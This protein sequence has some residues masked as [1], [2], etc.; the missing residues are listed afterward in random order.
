MKKYI[1]AILLLVA[2]NVN[3][4]AQL[5]GLLKKA[6]DKITEKKAEV[7]KPET[8]VENRSENTS[9]A[10]PK[11]TEIN[12]DVKF[13]FVAGFYGP[14]DGY[15]D[16]KKSMQ[17][18][19]D[20][21]KKYHVLDLVRKVGEKGIFHFV[22][23]YPE[24]APFTKPFNNDIKI[25][26]SSE[27]FKEGKG[28]VNNFTS[29]SHIYARVENTKGT[30]KDAFKFTGK[31]DIL[32]ISFVAFNDETEKVDFAN[33][34]A[35]IYLT[36]K[37]INEKYIDFDILPEASKATFH[38]IDEEKYYSSTIYNLFTQ[39]NFPKSGNYKMGVEVESEVK[40][41]WGN[42]SKDKIQYGGYFDIIFSPSD[43]ATINIERQTIWDNRKIGIANAPRP[44]PSEWATKTSPLTMGVTQDKLTQM[45][46]GAD[47]KSLKLIKFFASSSSGGWT[48][49][50][51]QDAV[52]PRYRHSNQYYTVFY[53]VVDATNRN[54]GKCWFQT[55]G[56]R[57]QYMGGG[58]Y[59]VSTMDANNWYYTE[60][61]KMK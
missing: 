56:L 30:I 6:K 2:V 52:V 44:L 38:A 25:S 54:N 8:V 49:V 15:N 32:T 51:D 48:A 9:T 20:E 61:D 27:P 17:T 53:K 1:I 13:E 35:K 41:E 45:L 39:R 55:F 36:E 58:T 10:I 43:V 42:A 60:C 26:F 4:Q 21:N 47:L 11:A 23:D 57:Q 5:G 14:S 59:G 37:E 16:V 50:Y 12:S 40:D 3:T 33:P 18:L 28:V 19:K 22:K 29:K 34:E 31:N 24:L 7:K 46:C